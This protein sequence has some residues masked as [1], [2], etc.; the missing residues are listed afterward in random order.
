VS[1]VVFEIHTSE[2]QGIVSAG[3]YCL[4]IVHSDT[5]EI[6]TGDPI[7]AMDLEEV[8][9]FIPSG[10]DRTLPRDGDPPSLV[11]VWT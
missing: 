1:R 5:G 3:L 7:W 11:E 9:S 6:T 10:L 8:R 2:A 4:R